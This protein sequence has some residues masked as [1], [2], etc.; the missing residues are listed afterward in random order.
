MNWGNLLRKRLTFSSDMSDAQ[1]TLKKLDLY[2]YR[3]YI[4]CHLC[5]FTHQCQ[6]SVNSHHNAGVNSYGA[7]SLS[8]LYYCPTRTDIFSD[9]CL[10][11]LQISE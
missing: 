3:H 4:F 7:S 1:K 11:F 8:L 6:A 10:Y 5:E 9:M 2:V